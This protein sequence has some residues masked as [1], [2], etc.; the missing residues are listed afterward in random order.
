MCSWSRLIIGMPSCISDRPNIQ[1]QK[2][3]SAQIAKQSSV[4]ASPAF[5]LVNVQGTRLVIALKNV[6]IW[7]LI[8]F[9]FN[10]FI[11]FFVQFCKFVYFMKKNNVIYNDK[12]IRYQTMRKSLAIYFGGQFITRHGMFLFVRHQIYTILFTLS[13]N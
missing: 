11:T 5:K 10:I 9:V 4:P 12:T 1:A 8:P 6:K 13:R 7:P 2:A 3:T